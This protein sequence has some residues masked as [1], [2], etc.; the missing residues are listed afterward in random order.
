MYRV[1]MAHREEY[2]A[3]LAEEEAADE[4]RARLAAL[5]KRGG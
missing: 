3:V 5:P 2:E 4:N 1:S